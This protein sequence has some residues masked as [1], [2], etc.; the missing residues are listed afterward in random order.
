M[1]ITHGTA[2]RLSP[3]ASV[4]WTASRTAAHTKE[5]RIPASHPARTATKVPNNLVAMRLTASNENKI[6]CG[7]WD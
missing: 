7:H 5:E 2:T 1:A 6:S 3:E 4:G